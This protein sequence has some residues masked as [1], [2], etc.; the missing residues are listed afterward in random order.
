MNVLT[1]TIVLKDTFFRRCLGLVTSSPT[2]VS[3]GETGSRGAE[4]ESGEDN[5]KLR[6]G[7]DAQL[8]AAS[9]EGKSSTSEHD[10]M[11]ASL[12]NPL[13]ED[14]SADVEGMMAAVG[15]TAVEGATMR[16]ADVGRADVGGEDVTG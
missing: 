15:G 2:I 11:Q 10:D 14:E 9:A 7:S 8:N 4:E 1:L 5:D 3:S 13:V 12:Q 6:R 16:E